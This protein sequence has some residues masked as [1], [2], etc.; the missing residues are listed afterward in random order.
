MGKELEEL[1]EEAAEIIVGAKKVVVF[2]GAGV[3]TESGIPDF[4]SPG[5]LWTKYNPDDFTYQKFLKDPEVRKRS[6]QMFSMFRM[7]DLVQPNPA[8]YAVAELDKMGKLDCVITQNVDGLHQKAGVPEEK[9]I[10]L[11]GTIKFV[12][13]LGCRKRYSIEEIAKRLEEGGEEPVCDDCGGILKSATIS[14]GE[15]MPI[16]E[17][18]EA[19]RRSRECDLCLVLG[20]SLVVYPAAYMPIYA[21]ESGAKLV[22]I[23]VGTTSMDN[24]AH[25][26]INE[27]VG[28]VMPKIVER[29]KSRLAS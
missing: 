7:M 1:I 20:S 10:E 13:C 3:S 27:K 24:Y 15:P 25:V 9:V 26:R 5:G 19:E 18:A 11:H 14:F 21:K 22:I 8:H 2:T 16:K 29:V 28:E 23:N 6:W 4:R 17:T 12:K